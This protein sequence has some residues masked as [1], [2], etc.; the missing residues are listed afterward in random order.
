MSTRQ[1][2]WAYKQQDSDTETGPV[3]E[4]QMVA[5]VK[6][7]TITG[8][9]L[10]RSSTRTKDK[11]IAVK[12]IP[13]VA[14]FIKQPKDRPTSDPLNSQAPK[15]GPS[16][17]KDLAATSK[18]VENPYAAPITDE[19]ASRSTG[20]SVAAATMLEGF[21]PLNSTMVTWLLRATMLAMSI[22][23]LC[24]LFFILYGH[25]KV[26]TIAA[27]Q[28][29]VFYLQLA[30]F[31]ATTIFFLRWKHQAYSNLQ[32]A[33]V[34][35]LKTS[36]GW[37]V[38]VYFIPLVQLYRPASAMHEIQ[39]RSKAGVGASVIGWWLLVFLGAICIRVAQTAPGGS[40]NNAGN[41]VSLIGLC[42]AIAAGYLLLR[43]IR[44]VTEKQRR[45]GLYLENNLN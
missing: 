36:A 45:Y 11:W 3:T 9:T 31:I 43:I 27:V 19:V 37:C 20:S 40:E 28:T 16:I 34:E 14:K 8:S 1:H 7:G 13:A 30:L 23:G 33:C 38:A 39:S 42:L 24:L 44:T 15:N 4:T 6:N 22:N 35:K 25:S 32:A 5:L 12:R 29:G 41:A 21:K 17:S 18:P 26:R 10:V 2:E